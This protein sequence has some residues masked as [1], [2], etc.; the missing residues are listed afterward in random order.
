M[1]VDIDEIIRKKICEYE[2][3]I[4]EFRTSVNTEGVWLFLATLGCWS[5]EQGFAQFYAIVITFI[6]FTYRIHAKLKDNRPFSKIEK[7]IEEWI[8][9]NLDG[10]TQKARLYD[11][12][13]IKRRKHSLIYVFKS[14]PIFILSYS[15]VILT[16]WCL[17]R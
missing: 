7:D 2:I 6:M 8:N 17:I 13:E 16:M 3:H 9:S 14:S 10:D 1:Q 11:I 4:D 15:F 5:V 12:S